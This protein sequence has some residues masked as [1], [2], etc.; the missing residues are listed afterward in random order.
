MEKPQSGVFDVQPRASL[1]GRR[2]AKFVTVL[3]QHQA[4]LTSRYKVRT[5]GLFGSYVHGRQRKGSDLDVLVEFD[6]PPGL[7]ELIDLE[8]YL[9]D[10][11]GVKVDLVMKDAL[12]PRIGRR[13][14][15]EVVPV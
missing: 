12:K 2:V 8:Y 3:H 15:A 13:I 1:R 10:L 6:D 14:L 9:G 7:L 11:L 5:L 4:E